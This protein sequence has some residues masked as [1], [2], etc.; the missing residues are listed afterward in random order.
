MMIIV[1][2]DGSD[3]D[4]ANWV[5]R[6][7]AEDILETVPD[8]PELREE[9]EKAQAFGTLFL[10]KMEPDLQRRV[11]EIMKDVAMLTMAEARKWMVD[12]RGDEVVLQYVSSILELLNMLE[13]HTS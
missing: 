13:L 9:L 5:F 10:D 12:Q 8:D 7:F 11:M 4:R 3:W 2:P 1:F 6:R